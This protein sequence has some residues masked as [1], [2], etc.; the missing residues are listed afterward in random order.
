MI[1]SPLNTHRRQ[2]NL[3]SPLLLKNP[4]NHSA[5]NCNNP[6]TTIPS[7][8]QDMETSVTRHLVSTLRARVQA[9][10]ATHHRT[11]LPTSSRIVILVSSMANTVSVRVIQGLN[12]HRRSIEQA[13]ILGL[14]HLVSLLSKPLHMVDLV[15]Q[16]MLKEV[17]IQHRINN[18]AITL[19]AL[20]L[21]MAT[22]MDIHMGVIIHPTCPK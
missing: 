15:M 13:T 2:P 12:L 17:A 8:A 18:P 20:R 22:A 4:T 21:V 11:T 3:M 14:Q 10:L 1:N 6:S 19:M 5:T 7:K 16:Q 9:A